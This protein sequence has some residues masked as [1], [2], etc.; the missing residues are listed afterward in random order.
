MVWLIRSNA[1]RSTLK[2]NGFNLATELKKPG[3]AGLIGVYLVFVAVVV[4]TFTSGY[5]GSLLPRYVL[6][7]FAFLILF[8][9]E[10]WL[11]QSLSKL[12]HF[13]FSV[14]SILIIILFSFS[15]DF[16]SVP[17]LFLLLSYQ[18]S[19][20]FYGRTR[21]AWIAGFVLMTGCSLVLFLGFF[22]G[23]AIALTDMAA[24]IVTAGFVI[25]NQETLVG[26]AESQSLLNK[27]NETHQQL[28]EYAK[29]ADELAAA[30]ER[31]SLAASLR[32]TV[33]QIIFGISLTARSAQ[34]LLD[35]EPCRVPAE[36]NR[37]QSMTA[38]ALVH[39]RS[40]ISQLQTPKKS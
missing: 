20:F 39:L 6:F 26:K 37:L 33:S 21:W 35:K 14:Q 12:N 32:D 9:C 13:Y 25:I 24:E 11:P 16:D 7:E 38:E 40:L 34:L 22:R 1:M 15:P 31:D 27:L 30:K 4:R 29:T 5:V 10:W 8:T 2:T 3:K 36:V 28:Q 23:F 19:L 17:L 18:A